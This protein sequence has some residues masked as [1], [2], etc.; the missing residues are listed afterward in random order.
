MQKDQRFTM[1]SPSNRF[2]PRVMARIDERE[3]AQAR[4]RAVIGAGL[5]VAAAIALLVL[6]VISIAA[7]ID[8]LLASPGA[9]FTTLL[10]V[11]PLIGELLEAA[12]VVATA[13]LRNMNGSLMLAYALSVLGLT[14]LW[15]RVATGT[16]QSPLKI[17]VGGQRK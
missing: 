1:M 9:I 4:R 10:A 11:S 5:L 16:F 6:I 3:R 17:K 2:T 15:A 13:L 7:W 14:V 12:W 8:V